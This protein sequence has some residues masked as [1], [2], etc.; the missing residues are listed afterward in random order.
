MLGLLA[1]GL[2]RAVQVPAVLGTIGILGGAVLAWMGWGIAD[3]A[4]RNRLDPV[5]GSGAPGGRSL[6]RAGLLTTVSNPYWLL[7][8]A[9]IG[10]AYFV[11]FSRFGVAAILGLFFLGHT[12][13]DLGWNS[14][15]AL[16]LG[17]GRR[18]VRTEVFRL[19]LGVCGVFL[20][21][22]SGYFIYTGLRYLAQ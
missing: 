10:A 17:A 15:L 5:A 1:L 12:A 20:L 2:N 21:A 14:F 4:R 11:R 16:V 8:W 13:L 6:V 7:W 3:A 22:M 19:V 9:T 18:R